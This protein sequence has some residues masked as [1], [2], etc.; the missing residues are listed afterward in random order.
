VH[1]PHGEPLPGGQNSYL[2]RMKQI[3]RLFTL[4]TLLLGVACGAHAEFRWGPTAG[5]TFT[6]LKFKQDL[7]KVDNTVGPMAGVQGELMFPGIGFGID[8]GAI[9]NIQGARLHL[10]DKKIWAIDGYGTERSMLH[11]ISVPLNL[12]FKW[13]RMNGIEDMIAP[14][15]FGGPVFD[16]TIAHNKLD[17]MKYA[18]GS[19]GLQ[20]GFGI[21]LRKRW[22]VQASHV[23]GMTYALKAIK[24]QNFSAREDY[25]T[26]RLTYLF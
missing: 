13:T 8:I 11:T 20:A 2:I 1:T 6:T 16:F 15:V 4:V 24:L 26:V 5:A 7:I 3:F 10:G 22:Q 19:V 14:Y 21:E 18:G 12:R 17:A 25:W 23:W 9:Y